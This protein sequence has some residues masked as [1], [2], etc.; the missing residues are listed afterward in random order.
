M[1]ARG[2]SV[3][4]VSLAAASFAPE[5]FA[6][7]CTGVWSARA[8]VHSFDLIIVK[9]SGSDQIMGAMLWRETDTPIAEIRGTCNG[10]SLRFDRV[11]SSQVYE[12]TASGQNWVGQFSSPGGSYAWKTLA[13]R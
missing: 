2:L 4:A 5:A 13:R 6:A 9:L 1:S 3:L 10:S 11:G 7:P 12:A 8:N